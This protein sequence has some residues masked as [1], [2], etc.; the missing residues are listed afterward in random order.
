MKL[1]TFEMNDLET[2]N[3][4]LVEV[5]AIQDLDY[6]MIP[7]PALPQT[8]LQS[9]CSLCVPHYH[10]MCFRVGGASSGRSHGNHCG[11]RRPLS[12]P[13]PC[14]VKSRNA[15][16]RANKAYEVQSGCKRQ[17]RYNYV[18]CNTN[19]RSAAKS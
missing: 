14:S 13:Q 19:K 3:E 16:A 18:I 12:S 15:T 8:E 2:D 10:S 6:A 1:E 9:E 17:R 7:L 11:T 4:I 5:P